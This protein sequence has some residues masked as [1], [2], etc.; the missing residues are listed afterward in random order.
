MKREAVLL[1]LRDLL[2]L[3]LAKHK[4]EQMFRQEEGAYLQ[5]QRKLSETDYWQTSELNRVG[6]LWLAILVISVVPSLLGYI[7]DR[8]D[9]VFLGLISG[10]ANAAGTVA[11]ILVLILIGICVS[12]NVTIRS[13]QRDA[14]LHNQEEARREEKNKEMLAQITQ[15]WNVRKSY[16]KNELDKVKKLLKRA[17]SLNLLPNPYR[18]LASVYYIYN[19]MSSSQENLTDTLLHSHLESGVQ[20]ILDKLDD[21]V[22]QNER[23]IFQNRRIEAANSQLTAKT[24]QMLQS[25]QNVQADSRQAAQY[26]ALAAI[27]SGTSAYFSAANYLK[28]K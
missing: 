1:Y 27:Y 8:V 18:N 16:L 9:S 6:P 7:N 12:E 28:L 22:I 24:N 14:Q 15:K 25:L 5:K 13:Q 20:R 23:V 4:L 11:V 3:E 2:A 21:I 17:Y 26:S 10:W 19:Y